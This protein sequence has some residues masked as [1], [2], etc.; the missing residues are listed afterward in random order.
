MELMW[1]SS[2]LNCSLKLAQT[3]VKFQRDVVEVINVIIAFGTQ[4]LSRKQ[5]LFTCDIVSL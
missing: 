1:H 3:S 5:R 2:L 4:I